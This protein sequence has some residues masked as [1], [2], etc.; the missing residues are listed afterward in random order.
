MQSTLFFEEQIARLKSQLRVKEDQEVADLLGMSKAAFSARKTRGSFPEDKVRALA[1]QR[2]ELGIDVDYVLTGRALGQRALEAAAGLPGRLRMLREV[3]GLGAVLK[4]SGATPEQWV[5]WEAAE[6][7]PKLPPGTLQRLV[8]AFDIDAAAFLL[9]KPEA[10]AVFE[11]DESILLR[12]YRACS[13]ADQDALRH[14][15]AFLAGRAQ[16]LNADGRYPKAEDE[17]AR[18]VHSPRK[19]KL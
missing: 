2:P 1:Q 7:V 18:T 4:A 15:A 12:N 14:Q 9:G 19:K 3:E 10:L 5:K 13:P 6:F 11:S 16:S 8:D 17:P